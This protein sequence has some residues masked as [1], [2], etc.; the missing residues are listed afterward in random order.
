MFVCVCGERETDR[1][2][3]REKTRAY[4]IRQTFKNG[5]GYKSCKILLQVD[6]K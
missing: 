2:R 1:K 5:L 4:M 6:A 3:K